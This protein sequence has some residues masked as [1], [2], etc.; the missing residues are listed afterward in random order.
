MLLVVLIIWAAISIDFIIQ[1]VCQALASH[2]EY[3]CQSE[4]F[5]KAYAILFGLSAM[6]LTY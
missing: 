1:L 2:E 5:G 6:V 3:E 4:N